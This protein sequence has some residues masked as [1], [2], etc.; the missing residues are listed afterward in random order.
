VQ[1]LEDEMRDHIDELKHDFLRNFTVEFD[2][3]IEKEPTDAIV[4]AAEQRT[5]GGIVMGTRGKRSR[6][7]SALL[8]SCSSDVV[9]RSDTPVLI[10]K[11]G[12]VAGVTTP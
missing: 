2:V 1:R 7:S 10:V 4:E 6:F 3:I 12:T 5:V 11:E 8:G 9:L